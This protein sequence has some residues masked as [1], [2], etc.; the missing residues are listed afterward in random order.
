MASSASPT[1]G[2]WQ[3]DD[4]GFA[5]QSSHVLSMLAPTATA[6]PCSIG[7]HIAVYRL[8]RVVRV[9]QWPPRAKDSMTRIWTSSL[10]RTNGSMAAQGVR[11][12]DSFRWER[13]QDHGGGCDVPRL[14][15]QHPIEDHS[16]SYGDPRPK[17]QDRRCRRGCYC[18]DGYPLVLCGSEA[19]TSHHWGVR[20]SANGVYLA[21]M[22]LLSDIVLA[23]WAPASALAHDMVETALVEGLC[24]RLGLCPQQHGVHLRSCRS[25]S[26]QS[27]RVQ[28][29][30]ERA[31][32]AS[33]RESDSVRMCGWTLASLLQDLIMAT[34]ALSW[35]QDADIQTQEVL[36]QAMQPTIPTESRYA[37]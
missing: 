2:G 36:G 7:F 28:G 1:V 27:R 19:A 35:N 12:V 17:R 11:R 25:Y 33:M 9:I 31:H 34:K 30:D 14:D 4:W 23:K 13:L 18:R 29:G 26:V 5:K 22:Y 16:G 32:R 10:V 24:R 21:D 15:R 3:T 8:C 20:E 37:E 6:S